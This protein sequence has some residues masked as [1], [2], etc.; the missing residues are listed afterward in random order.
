M[1]GNVQHIAVHR[2]EK[3]LVELLANFFHHCLLGVRVG[4]RVR[5]RVRVGVSVRVRVRI[6]VR[7]S[8]HV[9]EVQ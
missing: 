4:V 5:V 9:A 8:L 6:K 2:T 3:I 7:V 1:F